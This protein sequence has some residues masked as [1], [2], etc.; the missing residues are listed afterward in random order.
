[1]QDQGLWVGPPWF[2]SSQSYILSRSSPRVFGKFPALPR[3]RC[4][5]RQHSGPDRIEAV[6]LSAALLL[7]PSIPSSAILPVLRTPRPNHNHPQASDNRPEASDNRP[8]E[9]S[10]RRHIESNEQP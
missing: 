7:T 1:M 4:R 8:Y 3:M 10:M 6:L 5:R 9:A 2:A